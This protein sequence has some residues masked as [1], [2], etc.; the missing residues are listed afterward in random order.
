MKHN[1]ICRANAGRTIRL[2][3]LVTQFP[4]CFVHNNGFIDVPKQTRL[5]PTR[6]AIPSLPKTGIIGL[7]SSLLDIFSCTS[8]TLGNYPSN[9]IYAKHMQIIYKTYANY[10][11]NICKLYT[12]HMQIRIGCSTEHIEKI[13]YQKNQF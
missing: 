13:N 11:Q 7:Y 10:I 1:K 12:K 9:L 6:H 8:I 2:P 3:S 4:I 5:V